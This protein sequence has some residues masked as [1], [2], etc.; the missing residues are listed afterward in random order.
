MPPRRRLTIDQRVTAASGHLGKFLVPAHS[1]NDAESPIPPG[2]LIT[3]EEIPVVVPQP[4]AVVTDGQTP[5]GHPRVIKFPVGGM[6]VKINT[7]NVAIVSNDHAKQHYQKEL[8]ER[9]KKVKPTTKI[10]PPAPLLLP[11]TAPAP[12]QQPA[13]INYTT[14]SPEESLE[15]VEPVVQ[16]EQRIASTV[17]SDVATVESQAC[18]RFFIPEH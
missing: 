10:I 6:D 3:G 15:E 7:Q 14:E 1:V 12:P 4:R 5:D 13:L 16:L 11:S 18:F 8:K 9:Q 17:R 2:K